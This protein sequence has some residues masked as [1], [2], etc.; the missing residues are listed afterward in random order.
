MQAGLAGLGKMHPDP[1][2]PCCPVSES[3]NK[4]LNGS[5]TLKKKEEGEEKG[6]KEKQAQPQGP[7][8]SHHGPVTS[9][10]DDCFT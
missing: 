7:R 3:L 5:Q 6:M 10:P 1:P 9:K 8:V 4:S 2:A